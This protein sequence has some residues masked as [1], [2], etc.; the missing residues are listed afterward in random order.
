MNQKLQAMLIFVLGPLAVGSCHPP[1]TK[2]KK[3][4]LPFQYMVG[5]LNPCQHQPRL[6][7]WPGGRH[8]VAEG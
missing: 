3:N 6:T 5:D 1:K 8:H 7:M 2:Q 4:R